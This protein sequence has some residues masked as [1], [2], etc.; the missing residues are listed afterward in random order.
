MEYSDTQVQELTQMV[1]EMRARLK[2]K[3]FPKEY[4]KN[5]LGSP[6]AQQGIQFPIKLAALLTRTEREKR[7][8]F[9]AKE[10]KDL[11]LAEQLLKTVRDEASSPNERRMAYKRVQKIMKDLDV[12][13]SSQVLYRLELENSS[14][15][16]ITA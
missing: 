6:L 12:H 16:E 4:A 5:L 10:R 1:E 2:D 7:E 13:L 15:K 14:L 3:S 11:Y 9:T 8:F